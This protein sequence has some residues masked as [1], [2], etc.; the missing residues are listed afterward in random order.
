MD[1]T[2][3]DL[4]HLLINADLISEKVNGK[5]IFIS[6]CIKV[7]YLRKQ[8]S[9]ETGGVKR[10]GIVCWDDLLGVIYPED[11]SSMEKDN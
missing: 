10:K 9:T 5:T 1:G 6:K 4:S 7:K 3:K 2:F 8:T 11:R